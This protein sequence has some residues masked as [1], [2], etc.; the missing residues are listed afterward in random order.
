MSDSNS[1]SRPRLILTT[2]QRFREHHGEIFE[3]FVDDH[4]LWLS[5]KTEIWVTGT[6]F[7]TL[8]VLID[9]LNQ[10]GTRSERFFMLTAIKQVP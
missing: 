1:Q 8:K 4:F 9:K 10:K 7:E 5:Q 2:T 6:T 3:K